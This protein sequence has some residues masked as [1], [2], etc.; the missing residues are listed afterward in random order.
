MLIAA[1]EAGAIELS[2]LAFQ[3][4][5]SSHISSEQVWGRFSCR[6]VRAAE[7]ISEVVFLYGD[8]GRPAQRHTNH[9]PANHVA[10]IYRTLTTLHS[11][12]DASLPIGYFRY[13]LAY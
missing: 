5:C 12:I 9:K 8:P 10:H 3:L 1:A 4:T 2:R 6:G 11:R 7:K 13:L